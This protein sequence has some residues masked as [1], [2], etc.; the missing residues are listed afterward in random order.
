MRSMLLLIGI[1]VGAAL[2]LGCGDDQ[3][4]Q[5]SST[6]TPPPVTTQRPE[7]A[8][9]TTHGNAIYDLGTADDLGQGILV[10]TGESKSGTI[11][12][13]LFTGISWSPDGERI[14]FAGTEGEASGG[15]DEP[16]DIY[17]I[18]ADGTDT[19][20]ISDVGDAIDPLW[21]PDGQTIV[22]TRLDVRLAG[23]AGLTGDRDQPEPSPMLR[24][25]LWSIGSDGDGLTQLAN[26]DN[27]EIYAAGSFSPD[28]SRLA[29][30]RSELDFDSIQERTEVILMNVDGSDPEQLLD[31]ARDSAFSPDGKQI[32]FV[33]DRDRNGSLSYGDRTFFANDLYVMNV[34]G[35][36]LTRLTETRSLNEADPSWL[37][38]GSRLAYQRGVQFQNAEAMSILQINLD[39]SC[40]R[41]LLAG[42]GHG[43]WYASPAWRPSEP[44]RGGGPLRCWLSPP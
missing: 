44:R 35:S 28:G 18:H 33:S 29:V 19:V 1:G 10:L 22:F 30:T 32:A 37:P 27:F 34:D 16:T 41:E 11:V 17:S 2:L 43:P 9:F 38:G 4:R 23:T 13:Q 36:D 6:V 12:P 14:A 42:S 7:L 40:T 15:F 21:S 20:Q 31:R 24:G 25:S 3:D 39:G 26:A 8:F 5:G